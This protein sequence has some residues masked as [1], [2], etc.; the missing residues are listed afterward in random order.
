MG[1]G[2]PTRKKGGATTQDLPPRTFDRSNRGQRGNIA[3]GQGDPTPKSTA[4]PDP[5]LASPLPDGTAPTAPSTL[6]GLR[7]ASTTTPVNRSECHIPPPQLTNLTATTA[8][9]AAIRGSATATPSSDASKSEMAWH[10][11]PRTPRSPS[12]A[13]VHDAPAPNP[14]SSGCYDVLAMDGGGA[15]TPPT[16]RRRKRRRR[17]RLP[18]Q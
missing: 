4:P 11:V 10:T 1:K 17:A 14:A 16:P 7:S 12:T 18:P 5:V 2:R 13:M 9:P 3:A 15:P 8:A 6:L